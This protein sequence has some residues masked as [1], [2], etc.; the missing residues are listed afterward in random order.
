MKVGEMSVTQLVRMMSEY[1]S[2]KGIITQASGDEGDSLNRIGVYYS[3]I[4]ALK[5]TFDDMYT[6]PSSG[7]AW[8]EFQLTDGLPFG[9]FRR[10][11]AKLPDG[12]PRWFNNP[13]NVTRDQMT[14]FE[15]ALAI[16]GQTSIARA[17]F[18]KRATRL[19]LHFSTQNDGADGG[20]LVRFKFPDLP[21]MDE[22][23]NLIRA[24]RYKILY[25]FLV[26]ADLKLLFMVKYGRSINE[27]S[28]YDAD[29]QLLPTVLASLDQP[30]FVTKYVKAAYAKTDAPERLRSYYSE[31]AYPDGG[32][33]N[34]IE[35]LGEL[36]VHAFEKL[37][38][39]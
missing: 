14:T 17:H 10:G 36:A 15:A 8:T 7:L 19:F 31:A 33:R 1:R 18:W 24:T 6:T 20:P 11:N 3:V 32:T 23:G 30:T 35:P 27:R 37:I 9:R 25:P 16:N 5:V 28:L 4:G 26:L 12:S 29:N 21:T 34:G 22:L 2:D 13:D 38:K 39:Q